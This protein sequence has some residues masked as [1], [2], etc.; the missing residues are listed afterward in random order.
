MWPGWP[1]SWSRATWCALA[2][3][4]GRPLAPFAMH[5]QAVGYHRLSGALNLGVSTQE[6]SG[7]VLPDYSETAW[8]PIEAR[9]VR[10]IG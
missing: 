6:S 3:S 7:G 10:S 9:I 1:T 5:P 8:I 2:T 4:F